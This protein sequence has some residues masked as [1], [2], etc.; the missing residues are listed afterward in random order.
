MIHDCHSFPSIPLLRDLNQNP[1]RPDFNIGTDN[2]H[3]PQRLIDSSVEF[4][5]GKG[6]SLGVNWPYCGT[7]VPMGY[8]QKDKRVQ[9]IMLEINRRLYLNEPTNEKASRYGRIKDIV[10]E[11]IQ[12]LKKGL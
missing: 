3:T 5:Q 6:Y 7:I 2:F 1:E 10:V 11:Y 8:Y 4:F 12:M 9:S